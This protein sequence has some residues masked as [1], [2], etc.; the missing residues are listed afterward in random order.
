MHEE[1]A[2]NF[3]NF[4]PFSLLFLDISFCLSS[5]FLISISFSRWCSFVRV[6]R[7]VKPSRKSFVLHKSNAMCTEHQPKSLKVFFFDCIFFSSWMWSETTVVWAFSY[8]VVWRTFW[9]SLKLKFLL[10]FVECGKL[11]KVWRKKFLK[12]FS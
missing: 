10:F 1:R 11:R 5:F 3:F 9:F 4:H 8:C 12:S 6:L 7:Y 2:K